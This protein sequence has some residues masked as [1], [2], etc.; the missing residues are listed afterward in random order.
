MGERHSREALPAASCSPFLCPRVMQARRYIRYT[1]QN[2][3]LVA[4]SMTQFCFV[5]DAMKLASRCI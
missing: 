2:G 4:L 5:C 1:V 3:T